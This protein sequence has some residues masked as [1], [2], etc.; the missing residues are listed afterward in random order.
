MQMVVVD[1]RRTL[2]LWRR[3]FLR[4]FF[5][6]WFSFARK[7]SRRNKKR[8]FVWKPATMTSAHN[9]ADFLIGTCSWPISSSSRMGK[10]TGVCVCVCG[11]LMASRYLPPTRWW[12]EWLLSSIECRDGHIY[13]NVRSYEFSLSKGFFSII[14]EVSSHW[15]YQD[16]ALIFL[17][18]EDN[19]D[20]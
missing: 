10:E 11:Y 3:A 6:F 9:R 1:V 15:I 4:S 7:P 14:T 2:D 16:H 8:R 13:Q 12:R 18:R 19:D 20:V 17:F 5:Y